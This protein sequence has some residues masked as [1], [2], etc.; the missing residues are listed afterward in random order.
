MPH[1]VKRCA[2]HDGCQNRTHTSGQCYERYMEL[3]DEPGGP[4][5]MSYTE[6]IMV[7]LAPELDDCNG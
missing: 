5:P 2:R 4:I 6:W 7:T 1:E 3:S